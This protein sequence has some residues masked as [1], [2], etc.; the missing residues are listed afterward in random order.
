MRATRTAL[1]MNRWKRPL[2]WTGVAAALA[3]VFVLYR[4]PDL[5]VTL[6]NRLWAC[7]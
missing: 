1:A 4:D 2:A 5:A 6:S 3:L 7:F